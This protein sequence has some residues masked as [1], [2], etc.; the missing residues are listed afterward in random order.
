MAS[1]QLELWCLKG[2]SLY[3]RFSK[4][5][6]CISALMLLGW[7]IYDVKHIIRTYLQGNHYRIA[8]CH[9]NGKRTFGSSFSCCPFSTRFGKY[10]SLSIFVSNLES[11][12]VMLLDCWD[13]TC[14]EPWASC[15]IYP[16]T[17]VPRRAKLVR[18]FCVPHESVTKV[19]VYSIHKRRKYHDIAGGKFIVGK[20]GMRLRWSRTTKRPARSVY[21]KPPSAI[22][23]GKCLLLIDCMHGAVLWCVGAS[24]NRVC[25]SCVMGS[26]VVS[27][28]MHDVPT[29][30]IS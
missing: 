22:P 15:Y 3:G 28:R 17:S 11:R 2:N 5:N 13:M 21:P 27:L 19:I 25:V 12:A 20:P 16:K 14:M 26:C 10:L 29:A 7:Y 1:R 6:F 9:V 8:G 24:L 18:A 4:L 23:D 30:V